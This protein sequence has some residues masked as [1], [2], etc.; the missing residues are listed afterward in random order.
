M[1]RI[2]EEKE[3]GGKIIYCTKERWTH[4]IGEHSELSG[5]LEY[6]KTALEKPSRIIHFTKKVKYYYLFIKTRKSSA[7]HLLLIVKYLNGEGYIITAYFVR[8]I[9]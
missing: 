4:I 6:V 5:F 3:K 9:K 7:K 2:F 1:T 8:N